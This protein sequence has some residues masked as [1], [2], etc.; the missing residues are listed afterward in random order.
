MSASALAFAESFGT[1]YAN[2]LARPTP[3]ASER[4]APCERLAAIAT[5]YVEVIE[6]WACRVEDVIRFSTLAAELVGLVERAPAVCLGMA[7]YLPFASPS[8]R[9]A[10]SAAVLGIHLGRATRLDAR[11]QHTVAKAALFMNLPSLDLQDD[12][13]APHAIPSDAQRITLTRHPQLAAEL[14]RESPGADLAWIEAVLQHHEA[15]DGS[16]Y[17]AAL[18]GDEICLEARIL[19]LVDVWYALVAPQ[20]LLRSAK[21]PRAALHWLLSR[22][23]QQFDA[24][25]IEALRR[26]TGICPPGTAV[27][28]A[29]RETALVVDMPSGM[30]LPRRVVAILGVHG[31]LLRDPVRRDTRRAHTAIRDFTTLKGITIPPAYWRA[32]WALAEMA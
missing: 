16:G 25:L 12:L 21:T 7:P 1:A 19:K 2:T 20:R 6:H 11:R 32:I 23:R 24:R 3:I 26:L 18:A 13:V 29:N 15:L 5:A 27:R 8:L 31:R 14:L 22:L 10:F 4:A 9:H 17:P 30:A 28:L